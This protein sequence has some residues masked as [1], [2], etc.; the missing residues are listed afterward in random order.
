MNYSYIILDL[1]E[2]SALQTKAA[3]DGMVE[4]VF[5]GM[6]HTAEQGLHLVLTHKPR[7]VFLEIASVDKKNGLSLSFISD[8]HRFLDDIPKIIITTTKKELAFEAIDYGVFEYLLKPLMPI[9]L[10]KMLHKLHKR[11]SVTASKLGIHPA[12]TESS[13]AF[14]VQSKDR[15]LQPLVLCIKS[16]GDYRYINA[17]EITYFEADNNSTDIYLMSGEKITAFKTLKHFESVLTFPFVRIHNSYMV[18]RNYIARIQLGNSL[19]FIRNST[20]KIPFSK[21]Y[22]R[23]IE[24]ILAEYA[25][26]NYIEI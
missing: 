8:L 17:D 1:T 24:V 12:K 23:N 10:L 6:A 15:D 7:L 11:E 22:K 16:Y 18:N 13:N 5:L 3:A 19:C 4:L 21:S 2:E 26:G 14:V 9:Q 25:N 20:T